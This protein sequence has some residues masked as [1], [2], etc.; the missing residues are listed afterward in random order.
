VTAVDSSTE[1]DMKRKA[2]AI[3]FRAA[4]LAGPAAA[5]ADQPP[6]Q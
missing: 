6:G 4:A 1:E 3:A 5:F 2:L